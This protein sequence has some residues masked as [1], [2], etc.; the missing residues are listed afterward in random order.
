MKKQIEGSISEATLISLQV[1]GS[2]DK[3]QHS[4]KYLT[5]RFMNGSKSTDYFLGI[6]EPQH[7]ARGLLESVEKAFVSIGS[8]LDFCATKFHSITT[9]GASEN[10][11]CREGLWKLLERRFGKKTKEK[12]NDLHSINMYPFT[13]ISKLF[14]MKLCSQ[15]KTLWKGD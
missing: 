15:Q 10:S 5:C 11:G 13:E 6:V 9:D 12:S 3:W 4:Y 14:V 7:G 8:Q 1:N 2:D